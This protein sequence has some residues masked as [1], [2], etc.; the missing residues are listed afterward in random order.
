MLKLS[1][2]ATM[3]S[4]LDEWKRVVAHHSFVLVVA[5]HL[6][7]SIHVLAAALNPS[8]SM[9]TPALYNPLMISLENPNPP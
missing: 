2:Q 8:Q 7:H 1:P 6:K 9:V 5:R 4:I 3:G